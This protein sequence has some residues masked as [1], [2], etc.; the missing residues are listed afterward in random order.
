LRFFF[1]ILKKKF[2]T[3]VDI[4]H[5]NIKNYKTKHRFDCILWLWGGIADFSKQEQLIV[6]RK[7]KTLLT[8]TGILLFD[9]IP[10]K[11]K[12]LTSTSLLD[13][14]YRISMGEGVLQE[15]IPSLDEI[16]FYANELKFKKFEQLKYRTSTNRNRIMFYF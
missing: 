8:N 9:S 10:I 1:K 14:N 7:L 12:P 4:Q 15:C 11:I 6:L 13:G 2:E 5:V 3:T 16:K